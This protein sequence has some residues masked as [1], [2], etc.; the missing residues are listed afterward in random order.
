MRR[1]AKQRLPVEDDVARVGAVEPRDHVERRRLPRSVRAD[2]TDDLRGLDV[3]GNTIERE[4]A[5]ETPRHVVERKESHRR[6]TLRGLGGEQRGVGHGRA[7]GEVLADVDRRLAVDRVLP[8]E[9]RDALRRAEGDDRVRL[10]RR[11]RCARD[12]VVRTADDRE[13]ARRR[14][15]QLEPA[16][17]PAERSPAR[18]A[19][20]PRAAGRRRPRGARAR[21]R[22]RCARGAAARTRASSCPTASGGRRRISS[23]PPRPRRRSAS[24]RSRR[25][26]RPR[27]APRRAARAARLLQ[28]AQLAGRD[29]QLVEAVRDVGV[30][31]EE[32]G[33]LRDAVAERAEEPALRA[34]TAG[35]AGTRPA[36]APRRASPRAAAA[37]PLRRAPPAP[38]RSRTRSPCRR[39]PASGASPA[40]RTGA[41]SAPPAARRAGS[42]ARARTAAGYSAGTPS[43]S[44][45]VNVNP[46]TPFVSASCADA[47]PPSGSAS[48]RSRYVTVS[49][50]TSR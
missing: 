38:A 39:A 43:S 20:R 34:S 15:V 11:E 27:T 41:P 8:L 32:A 29:V 50:T 35:R 30:V 3:K 1:G 14:E 49:S 7:A 25:V 36:S 2:E 12:V 37:A 48:S 24:R 5:A 40:P 17:R 18:G 46:S 47:K 13:L 28:P 9:Q 31:V 23:S 33:V 44:V 19:V 10:P 16:E 42:S 6:N 45:H 26:P 4:D 21:R 22:R